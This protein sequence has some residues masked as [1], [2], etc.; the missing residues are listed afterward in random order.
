MQ[1]YNCVVIMCTPLNLVHV[2]EVGFKM[3]SE[4]N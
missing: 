3:T 1:L 2:S 4:D